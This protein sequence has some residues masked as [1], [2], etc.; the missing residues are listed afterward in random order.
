MVIDVK[1]FI[2]KLIYKLFLTQIRVKECIG[3]RDRERRGN[4]L[5]DILKLNYFY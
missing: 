4:N 5:A 2:D 1:M 3:S